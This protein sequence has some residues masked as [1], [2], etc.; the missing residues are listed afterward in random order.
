MDT[1]GLRNLEK[2]KTTWPEKFASEEELFRHIHAGDRI[3]I[4][5]GCGEPSTSFR[6]W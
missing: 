4:G 1:E 2:M 5:T 6:L 3:F